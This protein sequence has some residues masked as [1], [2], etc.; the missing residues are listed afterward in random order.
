M[1]LRFLTERKGGGEQ[2]FLPFTDVCR[3]KKGALSGLVHVSGAR[4]GKVQGIDS[5]GAPAV[6]H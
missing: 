2:Y 5:G 6:A 4:V 3:A 1:R